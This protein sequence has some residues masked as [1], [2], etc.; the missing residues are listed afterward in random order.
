MP[1]R[2]EDLKDTVLKKISFDEY[3][4]KTGAEADV[5]VIGFYLKSESAG[6]DL[7]NYLS[8]SVVENRDV[9]LSPNPD[10]K[11][12]YMVFLELDRKEGMLDLVDELIEDVERVAG[13]LKWEVKTPYLSDYMPFAQGRDYLQ[14]DPIAFLTAAEYKDKLEAEMNKVAEP[15]VQ[16]EV[17][18]EVTD[19]QNESIM[20]FLHNSNLLS[21]DI[22]ENILS[23]QDARGNL[24]LEVVNFG[25]G[26]DVMGDL[27]ISESAIKVDPDKFLFDKLNSMLGEMKALPIDNYVVIYDPSHKD[28]LVT[29]TC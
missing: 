10:E 6:R 11:G 17:Q 27:G 20:E 8:N 4:P 29:R 13:K 22:V 24:N 25:Y 26:P 16:P 18:P 1:L 14:S 12:Y 5:A 2:H 21:A 23:M 28:V 9:E 7:Y 15:E 3:E 19:E